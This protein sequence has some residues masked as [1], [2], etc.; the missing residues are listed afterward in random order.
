MQLTRLNRT[1]L[2]IPPCG[3]IVASAVAV[4]HLGCSSVPQS[5]RATA[6]RGDRPA[7]LYSMYSA[8]G[9]LLHLLILKPR[10]TTPGYN[11]SSFSIG[12]MESSETITWNQDGSEHEFRFTYQH[13]GD[14]PLRIGNLLWST[15]PH[16]VFVVSLDESWTPSVRPL[17]IRGSEHLGVLAEIQKALPDDSD[18]RSLHLP[19]DS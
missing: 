7:L 17:N 15:M 5:T 18:I 3:L 11:G 16:N 6:L 19:P 4:M 12:L 9:P 2:R 13:Y 8:D 1:R 10:D 14:H